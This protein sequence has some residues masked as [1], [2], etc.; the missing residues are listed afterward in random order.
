MGNFLVTGG[1]GFVGSNIVE[2]LL[3]RGESVRVLDNFSTGRRENIAAFADKIDLH[4]ASLTELD[5]CRAACDGI[6]YILHQGAIPSV[7]RSVDDPISSH[8]ANITGIVNLLEAMREK[9]CKRLVYA[10]SS[11]AYGNQMASPKVETMLPGPLSP[12]A[13]TKLCGEYYCQAYSQCFG[14][15]TLGLRYFNVFGPR[16]NP[17]SQYSAVIPKFI[18]AILNDEPPMVNGDGGQTRDFTYVA[19]N[20][21]GNI[22]AATRDGID[23]RGQ[24]M[25]LA[26]GDEI[27]LLD[28]I[29]AINEI[30]GK[31]VEPVFCPDRAGDVRNSCA[32]ISRARELLGFEPLVD[33]REGLRRTVEWYKGKS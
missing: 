4:E 13:V 7:P 8:H 12:Y 3:S 10:A 17:T 27:S 5:D 14:M 2:E 18:T 31:K 22:L 24:V 20:I 29:D 16:Q 32:D 28:L 15:E 1:A 25:N 30:T 26:C 21:E 23:A 9:K 6:D 11:S 19:N 33:F